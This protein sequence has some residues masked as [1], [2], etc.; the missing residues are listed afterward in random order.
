[1]VAVRQ[2]L[3]MRKLG[4]ATGVHIE[5]DD[6]NSHISA[7]KEGLT[8]EHVDLIRE[9]FKDRATNYV[10]SMEAEEAD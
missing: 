6:F 2:N 3:L 4:L 5:S 1:V 10:A 7:F 8:E 9:L